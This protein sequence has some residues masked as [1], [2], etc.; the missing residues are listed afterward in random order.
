[1]VAAHHLTLIFFLMSGLFSP[2]IAAQVDVPPLAT[3]KSTSFDY[4]VTVSL[5]YNDRLRKPDTRTGLN[6]AWTLRNQQGSTQSLGDSYRTL[7]LRYF[8]LDGRWTTP[9]ASQLSFTLRPDVLSNHADVASGTNREVDT[10]SGD[11]YRAKRPLEFVDQYELAL[12]REDAFEFAVGTYAN[13]NKPG[14]EGYSPLEFGL[15]TLLPQSFSAVR[16]T[17]RQ[18]RI[19]PVTGTSAPLI[20]QVNK[21][22]SFWILQGRDDRA[23][24]IQRNDRSFDEGFVAE[25]PYA[26]GA[27]QASVA[28]PAGVA[29]TLTVGL[30]GSKLTAGRKNELFG[31]VVIQSPIRLAF[32]HGQVGFDTRFSRE[33]WAK[34]SLPHVQ[35]EQQ[36][37]S[38]RLTQHLDPHNK[39]AMGFHYGISDRHLRDDTSA[40]EVHTGW[41]FDIGLLHRAADPLEIG[42]FFSDEWRVKNRNGEKIGAFTRSNGNA[43]SHLGRLSLELKYQIDSHS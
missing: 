37:H 17:M 4:D 35:L 3:P 36:S 9:S 2:T 20:D 31:N 1:M 40:V 38:L 27:L 32:I 30:L 15:E 41:Q 10:R 22:Y 18:Q 13:L 7:G 39:A 24:R 28:T 8:S 33:N 34:T 43:H 12:H 11:T 26:G 29:Y 19:A 42:L 23:N 6:D 5:L 21:A 25:D 16:L 14:M